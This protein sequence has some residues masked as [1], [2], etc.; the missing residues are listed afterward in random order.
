MFFLTFWMNLM[1]LMS[2]G[3][4]GLNTISPNALVGV[5]L[6]STDEHRTHG[7]LPGPPDGHDGD[8]HNHH[9]QHGHLTTP[10]NGGDHLPPGH[11]NIAQ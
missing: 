4:M 10:N 9:G 8:T 3:S 6:V 5:D 7:H 11:Q 1:L 2:G